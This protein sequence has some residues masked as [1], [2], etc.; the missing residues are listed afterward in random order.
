[1]KTIKTT[2]ETWNYVAK[3]QWIYVLHEP[4]TLTVMCEGNQNHMKYVI[5]QKSGIIH[6]QPHCKGYTNLFVIAATHEVSKNATYYM[7]RLDIQSDDC[8]ILTPHLDAIESTILKPIHLTNIDLM[9]LKYADKKLGEF[10]EIITKQINKP[11]IV[12]HAKWYTIALGI[13]SALLVLFILLKCCKNFGCLHWLQRLCCSTTDP[14]HG[15]INSPLIQ[16]FVNCIFDSSS[17]SS[18][19]PPTTVINEVVTYQPRR[20][21]ATVANPIPEISED[22]ETLPVVRVQSRQRTRR[23]TTPL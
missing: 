22:E 20:N 13:I 4:T 17:S 2:I 8:C 10:D 23:S 3:N 11:F 15:E 18:S 21:R 14:R 5:L 16:N 7:P 19:S 9:E 6:L 1:M 12:T